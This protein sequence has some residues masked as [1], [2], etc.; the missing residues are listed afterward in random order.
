MVH[1]VGVPGVVWAELIGVAT[2]R[3]QVCDRLAV[4]APAK[5]GTALTRT[6]CDYEREARVA[7][8]S[9]QDRFSE[10]R[11]T[12][13]ADALCVR[14]FIGLEVIEDSAKPPGPGSDR[15]PFVG[16]R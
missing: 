4:I 12:E 14:V 9:P 7:R 3:G 11:N 8:A 10:T 13:E 6:A 2:G 16:R 15:A 1:I 5:R